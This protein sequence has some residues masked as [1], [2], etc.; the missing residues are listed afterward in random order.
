MPP[1]SNCQYISHLNQN[2]D[3]SKMLVPNKLHLHQTNEATFLFLCFFFLEGRLRPQLLLL[4]AGFEEVVEH[5][6][7]GDVQQKK[8]PDRNQQ[9]KEL[10]QKTDVSGRPMVWCICNRRFLSEGPTT[11][12][13][14]SI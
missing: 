1:Y 6:R 2:V 7:E 13:T 10:E 9:Q 8:V 12:S 4:L 14:K 3:P 5:D 11:P